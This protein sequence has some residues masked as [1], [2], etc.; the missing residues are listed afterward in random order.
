MGVAK[1]PARTS[2]PIRAYL[3]W[4]GLPKV[5][6]VTPAG[7]FRVEVSVTSAFCARVTVPPAEVKLLTLL[8][9]PLWSGMRPSASVYILAIH[10]VGTTAWAACAESAARVRIA[11]VRGLRSRFR[12]VVLIG[13]LLRVMLVLQYLH[14]IDWPH[15]GSPHYPGP[16]LS[17]SPPFR[18]EK[19]EW[20]GETA[21]T[22]SK[23]DRHSP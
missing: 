13:H 7:M 19:R 20:F 4:A 9:Q 18:P 6:S 15:R 14:Q 12:V 10:C 2:R 21:S 23:P 1:V 5:V 17:A 8:S 16:L 22:R 3:A 11:K